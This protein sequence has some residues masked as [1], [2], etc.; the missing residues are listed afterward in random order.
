VAPAAAVIAF[1][2]AVNRR[3]LQ[4]LAGLMTDDHLFDSAGARVTGKQAVL[5]A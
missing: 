5:N 2:E 3:D 1:N 4:A